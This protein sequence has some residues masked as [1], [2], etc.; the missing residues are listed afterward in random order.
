MEH[1]FHQFRRGSDHHLFLG[2]C[3]R[4]NIRTNLQKFRN[5]TNRTWNA[6]PEYPQLNIAWNPFICLRVLPSSTLL[7]ERLRRIIAICRQNVL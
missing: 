5:T 3:I 4:A 7:V 2:N 1:S 6:S